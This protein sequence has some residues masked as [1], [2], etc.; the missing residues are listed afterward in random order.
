MS[1]TRCSSMPQ[2]S[3][4][5]S[6]CAWRSWATRTGSS[7]LKR[8]LCVGIALLVA[9]PRDLRRLSRPA[10]VLPPPLRPH[11]LPQFLAHPPR[12]LGSA[13]QPPARGGSFKRRGQLGFLLWRKERAPSR[14]ATAPIQN[15]FR[16]AAVVAAN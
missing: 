3:T 2:S 7:F 4:T 9:G 15:C 16:P 12:H 8:L 13:P 10:H 11:R 1:P 5:A 6:G 14:V